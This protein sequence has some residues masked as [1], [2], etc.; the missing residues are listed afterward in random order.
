MRVYYLYAILFVA[1][2]A[3]VY[4]ENTSDSKDGRGIPNHQEE[5]VQV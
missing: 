4:K 5:I 3:T 2:M 1:N